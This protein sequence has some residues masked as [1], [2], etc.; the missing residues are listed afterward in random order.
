M[1]EINYRLWQ[2]SGSQARDRK[3]QGREEAME[4]TFQGEQGLGKQR[5]LLPWK[6]GQFS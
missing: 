2:E 4:G 3:E 6:L 1:T 5:G